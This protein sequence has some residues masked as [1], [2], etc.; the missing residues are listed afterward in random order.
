M[1]A[2]RNMLQQSAIVSGA[3]ATFSLMLIP[4][5][6]KVNTT[7][8][9]LGVISLLLNTTI[10]ICYLFYAQRKDSKNLHTYEDTKIIPIMRIRTVYFNLLKDQTEENLEK[11]K[12][13]KKEALDTLGDGQFDEYQKAPTDRSDILLTVLFSVGMLFIILSIVS[14]YICH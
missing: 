3:I 12:L 8:L 9:L 7:L 13:G 2:Y 1:T 6:I 11:F 10:S 4:A 14:S 5:N